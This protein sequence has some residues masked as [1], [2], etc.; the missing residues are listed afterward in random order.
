MTDPRAYPLDC[1]LVDKF[2]R[3]FPVK[4]R[5]YLTRFCETMKNGEVAGETKSESAIFVVTGERSKES[6][7]ACGGATVGSED[8]SAQAE[9]SSVHNDEDLARTRGQLRR[10]VEASRAKNLPK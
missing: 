2:L 3:G 5:T 8:S 10:R 1:D 4:W 6:A 9:S 7:A